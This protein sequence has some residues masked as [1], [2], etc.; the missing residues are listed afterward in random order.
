MPY[1]D[2]GTVSASGVSARA[3][4][5]LAPVEALNEPDPFSMP[6]EEVGE[7]L[8]LRDP[9]ARLELR[10]TELLHREQNLDRAGVTCAIKDR[11][12][13]TCHACPVSCAH[14]PAQALS[15][16]CKVGREQEAVLTELGVLSCRDVPN[17]AR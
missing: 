12:D 3:D 9:R 11:D 17:P 7:R 16:L 1:P 4:W 10:V 14:N 15:A 13:T 5:F 2:C 8:D 6:I